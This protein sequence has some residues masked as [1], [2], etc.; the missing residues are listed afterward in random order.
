L[1]RDHFVIASRERVGSGKKAAGC[2]LGGLGAR[3]F[4]LDHYRDVGSEVYPDD[5]SGR[6]PVRYRLA[7]PLGALK[8]PSRIVFKVVVDLAGANLG[9]YPTLDTKLRNNIVSPYFPS[10]YVFRNKDEFNILMPQFYARVSMHGI[11][12]FGVYLATRSQR[13][14]REV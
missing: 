13:L 12:D 14:S 8:H 4:P 7:E 5:G 2:E 9:D 3:Q 6:V 10:K 11:S 1:R